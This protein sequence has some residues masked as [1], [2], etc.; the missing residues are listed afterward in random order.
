M[1][2]AFISHGNIRTC[3]HCNYDGLHLIDKGATLF[4][5]NVLSAL[6]NIAL[7][8]SVKMNSSSK[9]FSNSDDICAKGNAFASTKS[10]PVIYFL[11]I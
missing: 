10:I 5:E 8:Q 6:N 4:T 11:V 3:Y 2:L 1:N 7:P 9:S